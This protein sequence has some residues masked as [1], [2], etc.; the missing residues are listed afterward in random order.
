V[1]TQEV[2]SEVKHER[3]IYYGTNM[4]IIRRTGGHVGDTDD[5][6]AAT[7]RKISASA[8]NRTQFLLP[9]SM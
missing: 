4:T 9:S 7:K 2:N 5:P 8:A 6:E 3:L 1:R